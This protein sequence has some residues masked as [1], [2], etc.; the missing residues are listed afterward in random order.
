MG[1]PSS[2]LSSEAVAMDQEVNETPW[3]VVV[4]AIAFVMVILSAIIWVCQPGT[5]IH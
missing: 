2:V 1:A 3:F 5:V 4:G